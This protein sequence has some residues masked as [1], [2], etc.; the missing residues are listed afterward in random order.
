MLLENINSGKYN[1]VFLI[2]V[3][4]FIAHLYWKQCSTENMTDLTDTITV[5][6]AVKKV[7]NANIEAIRNLSSI[8]TK[9]QEGSLTIPGDLTV[10]GKVIVG[11]K[12]GADGEIK[13]LNKSGGMGVL[14]NANYSGMGGGAFFYPNNNTEENFNN[15]ITSSETSFNAIIK[16]IIVA[17]SGYE[18]PS[19]W[20]LCDGKNGTPDLR[21]RFIRMFSDNLE[22]TVGFDKF[23]I[24]QPIVSSLVP[25]N[26]LGNSRT[27]QD[28]SI[29]KFKIGET[30]GTDHH[31]LEEN[32][33]SFSHAH[34]YYVSN[35]VNSAGSCKDTNTV[36]CGD[37]GTGDKQTRPYGKISRAGHNNIPP[38]YALAY[39]IKL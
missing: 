11:S 28:S 14:V 23:V 4:L 27:N 6:N 18:A 13:V 1:L 36:V 9:L 24:S 3:A 2:V 20:A 39:I 35:K 22:G 17:W 29:F 5:E 26:I 7:Y 38:F 33:V 32:E 34:D 10:A 31:L 25:K 15:Y 16:G 12:D 8:A 37:A 19:G 21:G 30:G